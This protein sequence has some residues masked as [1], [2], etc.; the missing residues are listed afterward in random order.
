MPMQTKHFLRSLFIALTFFSTC[1]LSATIPGLIDNCKLVAFDGSN[2][3]ENLRPYQ[4]SIALLRMSYT[5]QTDNGSPHS[6]ANFGLFGAYATGWLSD[7]GVVTAGHAVADIGAATREPVRFANGARTGWPIWMTLNWGQ[8]RRDFKMTSG[9]WQAFARRNL[10]NLG[11]GGDVV[12]SDRQQG[13]TILKAENASSDFALLKPP[14]QLKIR[15]M[16]VGM[17][18]FK[19]GDRVITLG[20]PNGDSKGLM[21]CEGEIR[22]IWPDSSVTISPGVDSGMSGGPVV[23][24]D[25]GK[26]IAI[27]ARVMI[28]QSLPDGMEWTAPLGRP[29]LI[30]ESVRY[31]SCEASLAP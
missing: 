27:A 20:Y 28:V 31:I 23:H 7:I 4:S 3:P 19:V 26:V 24:V 11:V 16:P 22:Q 1:P 9:E 10:L 5:M 12:L 13:L 29:V 30:G 21:F 6:R 14:E 2:L 18:G 25:S 17:D 8:F 15:P